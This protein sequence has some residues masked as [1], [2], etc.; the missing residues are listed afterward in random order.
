MD[1]RSR[2][3]RRLVVRALEKGG[4]GHLG[5]ALSLIEILRILFEHHLKF[6]PKQPCW[7]ERDRLILSKGHGCLALYALLADHGY[8][9]IEELDSFC[10][11]E[12]RLGGHPEKDTL[13]GI[14][15][16]TGALGHGLSIGVGLALA[17]RL[18][19]RLHHIYVI[20]GDGEINEG[21]IWEAALTANKH[22]LSNL[23][24]I[25]DYNKLQSYGRTKEVLDL[26]P[27]LKKWQAFGF[28]S[29]EVDGHNLT[30]LNEAL[31]TLH[32]H[33]EKP[34]A[35]ICHTIK[36]KGIP[37]A[38]NNP[39]WHHRSRLSNQELHQLYAALEG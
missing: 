36:G 14:E 24:V 20:T 31:H 11:A 35:L 37:E 12:S 39:A 17:A 2:H 30:Q 23:T 15:A 7:I 26:E 28:H 4:R 10:K 34:K 25:I 1:H 33:Q 32:Q 16:S 19:K 22:R 5:P 6:D 18:Q 21:A 27:L 13:P 3:L 29:Q 38:E 8:F 9:P